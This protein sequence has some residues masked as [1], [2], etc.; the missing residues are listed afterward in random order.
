ML[1][2]ATVMGWTPSEFWS[3][4]YSDFQDALRGW[5]AAHGQKTLSREDVETAREKMRAANERNKNRGRK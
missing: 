3:A 2:A 1:G 5:N 4:S